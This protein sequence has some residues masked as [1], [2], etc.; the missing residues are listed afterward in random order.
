MS[1]QSA[2]DVSHLMDWRRDSFARISRSLLLFSSSS[3]GQRLISEKKKREKSC[4][5]NDNNGEEEEASER[6]RGVRWEDSL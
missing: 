6:P 2:T 1:G 4:P 5:S 3:V